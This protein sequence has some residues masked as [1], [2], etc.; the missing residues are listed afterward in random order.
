MNHKKEIILIVIIM[1][2]LLPIIFVPIA[3]DYSHLVNNSTIIGK[4]SGTYFDFI[5]LATPFYYFI[6]FILSNSFGTNE[7]LIGVLNYILQ[8][9]IVFSIIFILY[10]ITDL[11][12]I[13]YIC[14]ILYALI[15]TLNWRLNFHLD[16]L[17]TLLLVWICYFYCR[18]NKLLVLAFLGLV[19]GFITALKYPF[20]L[21]IIPFLIDILLDKDK[22]ITLRLVRCCI[23][24]IFL[25]LTLLIIYVPLLYSYI[26]EEFPKL[27]KD[28]FYYMGFPV[29]NIDDIKVLLKNSAFYLG[30]DIS[31]LVILLSTIGFFVLL[32]KNHTAKFFDLLAMLFIITIISLIFEKQ[33]FE[34]HIQHFYLFFSIFS[35]IGLYYSLNKL[36]GNFK[37]YSPISKMILIFLIIFALILSPILRWFSVLPAPVLYIFDK[38]KYYEMYIKQEV[39]NRFNFDIFKKNYSVNKN[40]IFD[41]LLPFSLTDSVSIKNISLL[42]NERFYINIAE[43]IE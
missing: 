30:W 6:A 16:S 40:Y 12:L 43:I 24:I 33:L 5:E 7:I 27:I 39:S 36:K 1:I 15:Y 42:N 8:L 22:K 13:G 19:I 20:V 25:I 10:K 31:L 37:S 4:E 32:A 26:Y 29:F 34:Y 28:H 3:I 2:I 18:Y 35:A 11:K 41:L 21:L 9:I 23:I 38:N 14:A 17:I